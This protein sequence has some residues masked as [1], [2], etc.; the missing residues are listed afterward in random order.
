MSIQKEPPRSQQPNCPQEPKPP[1]PYEVQNVRYENKAAGITLAGTLTFPREQGPF[2][3]VILIAGMGP[4]DR[5]YTMSNHKLF[6]VLA[7]YLTRQG[8]AVL[9]FDKRGVGQSTGIFDTTLTSADFARD[10]EAGIAYLKTRPEIN[11]QQIGLVGHSEGGLIASMVAAGSKDVA[12]VILMAGV[13]AT[14]IADAVE[15]T[16]L[17]L[18]ADGAS[19]DFLAYDRALRTQLL[20]IV[21]QEP[22][23]AKAKKELFALIEH[24]WQMLPEATRK[25]ATKL[26][27]AITQENAADTVAMLNSP[28]YRFYLS[29]DLTSVL[30]KL[31]IPVL[32]MAGG[33]DWVA[34][35][36]IVFPIMKKALKQASNKDFILRELPN[37]NHWLQTCATGALAEYGMGEETMATVA[38]Q[39]M[40]KWIEERNKKLLISKKRHKE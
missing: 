19:K 8:I 16:A 25:E 27:F 23:A 33:H 21:T 38:L 36:S 37:L 20:S 4:N 7:D 2:P 5:D 34:S 22:D 14:K 10:V 9:R 11:A 6:L 39:T 28:W 3:A 1:F 15:L 30:K 29:Y 32:A 18:R 35:P 26:P 13:L 31:T 40:A 24:H 17:Q 12:F